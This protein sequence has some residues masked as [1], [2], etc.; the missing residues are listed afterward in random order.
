MQLLSVISD[1]IRRAL[2]YGRFR[3]YTK[4][5]TLNQWVVSI[6]PLLENIIGH[7]FQQSH[8]HKGEYISKRD[9][10]D[11]ELLKFILEPVDPSITLS[12]IETAI[13]ETHAQRH[14]QKIF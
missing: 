14:A 10:G 13:K 1:S 12:Q 3:T 8:Y 6:E 4:S 11:S 5:S 2:E 9:I 7:K